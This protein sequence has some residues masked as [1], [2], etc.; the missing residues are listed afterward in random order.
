MWDMGSKANEI[1]RGTLKS[2]LKSKFNGNMSALARAVGANP[3]TV[4]R[5]ISRGMVPQSD[6]IPKICTAL[7]ISPTE[8][9]GEDIPR[10]QMR[11]AGNFAP[12]DIEQAAAIDWLVRNDFDPD[13]V[14]SAMCVVARLYNKDGLPHTRLWWVEHAMVVLTDLST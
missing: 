2:Q 10:S 7:G 11:N 12:N 1:F 6:M 3:S 9:L 5:W 8:L 4:A 13:R 14:V